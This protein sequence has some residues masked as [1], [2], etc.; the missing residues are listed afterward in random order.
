MDTIARLYEVYLR[1]HVVTTDSR[2]IKPG[3]IFF[4]FK[5]ETFDGNAFAQQALE[6]GAALCVVSDANCAKDPR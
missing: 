1:S 3:C 6:Q 5:G 2:A 4:A